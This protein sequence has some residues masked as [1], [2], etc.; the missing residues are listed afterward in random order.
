[1]IGPFKGQHRFLS[2]FFPVKLERRGVCYK[3]VEHFYQAMKTLDEEMRAKIV[4]AS[5]AGKAKQIGRGVLLRDDWDEVRKAVMLYALRKKFLEPSL[6]KKLLET[7]PHK[8]VEINNWH[9]N[10]WGVCA[11]SKC[12]KVVGLNYLGRLLMEVR[13]I[14]LYQ[15]V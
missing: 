8:L 7:I 2:N 14:L 9:D 10:F 3:S 5:T 13:E 4:S 12:E 6:R 1:M 15:K 11:C